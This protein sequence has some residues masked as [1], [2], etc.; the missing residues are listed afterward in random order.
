MGTIILMSSPGRN[1]FLLF[2]S[3]H[4]RLVSSSWCFANGYQSYTKLLVEFTFIMWA[5]IRSLWVDIAI[6]FVSYVTDS[7]V[8]LTPSNRKTDDE[9]G[10]KLKTKMKHLQMRFW[11]SSQKT[12]EE[13]VTKAFIANTA[14]ETRVCLLS[15][16]VG[17][18][19]RCFQINKI[20]MRF[21]IQ[22]IQN[23]QAEIQTLILENLN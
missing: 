5:T 11:S 20:T 6:C 7:L 19:M 16:C 21:N 18:K 14:L 13:A 12:C 17:N 4:W 23:F 8:T 3:C 1:T 9:D 2:S 22:G 15:K 10:R